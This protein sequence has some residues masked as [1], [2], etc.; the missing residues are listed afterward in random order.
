MVP[1]SKLQLQV[2]PGGTA[3]VS[4]TCTRMGLR[5]Q[6]VLTLAVALAGVEQVAGG[7]DAKMVERYPWPS[8][9]RRWPG[10]SMT[11]GGELAA[12][13]VGDDVALEIGIAAEQPEAV[14]DLPIDLHLVA[15]GLGGGKVGA[16]A[17]QK[18]GQRRKHGGAHG[19]SGAGRV[20]AP[21]M[22]RK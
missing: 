8:R 2:E 19:K 14:L 18:G 21:R 9:G 22:R 5:R 20:L 4:R 12:G 16:G 6:V 7:I 13:P 10:S 3:P 15:T 11:L 1:S 17:G